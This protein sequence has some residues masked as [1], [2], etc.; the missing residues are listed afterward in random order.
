[1]KIP[2]S[3]NVEM[4]D[5]KY[6]KIISPVLSDINKNPVSVIYGPAIPDAEKDYIDKLIKEIDPVIR[7]FIGAPLSRRT[8]TVKYEKGSHTSLKPG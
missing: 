6:P 7:T 4:S 2:K 1:M 3:S 5:E 8:I